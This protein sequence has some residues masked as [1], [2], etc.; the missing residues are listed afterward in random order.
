MSYK[1]EVRTCVTCSTKFQPKSYNQRFCKHACNPTSWPKG[2]LFLILRRDNFQCF[3]CGRTSYE[4][5]VRLHVDHL[6][7]VSKGGED[8]A[9]NAV[10]ACEDCSFTKNDLSLDEILVS[11]MLEEISYRNKASGIN[12]LV[13]V[14]FRK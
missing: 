7:P 3:F 12:P 8:N 11:T 5:R 1:D 14:N 10:A 9:S 4:H 6:I 13:L 2:K